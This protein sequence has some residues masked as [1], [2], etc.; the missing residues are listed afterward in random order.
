MGGCC[1]CTA[2]LLLLT[3][4]VVQAVLWPGAIHLADPALLSCPGLSLPQHLAQQAAKQ[5]GS[6]LEQLPAHW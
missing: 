4:G 6:D 5:G 3:M 1:C 2:A